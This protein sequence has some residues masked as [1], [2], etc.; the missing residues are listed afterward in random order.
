VGTVGNKSRELAPKDTNMKRALRCP[1]SFRR[2]TEWKAVIDAFGS[3]H[4]IG[5]YRPELS[6]R[7]RRT[8]SARTSHL[9]N[10]KRDPRGLGRTCPAAGHVSKEGNQWTNGHD[11][12]MS[13]GERKWTGWTGY[14]GAR[15]FMTSLE[16]LSGAHRRNRYWEFLEFGQCHR[17]RWGKSYPRITGNLH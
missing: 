9:H 17:R 12:G 13:K 6:A 1:F 10:A 2:C 11:V 15:K 7:T 14:R 3:V 4:Q 5:I 16:C 8:L